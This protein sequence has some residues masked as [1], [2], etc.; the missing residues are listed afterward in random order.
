MLTP[1]AFE[2]VARG[3]PSWPEYCK[4]SKG[5]HDDQRRHES[6]VREDSLPVGGG[7][8]ERIGQDDVLERRDGE[9]GVVLPARVLAKRKNFRQ[10]GQPVEEYIRIEGS[11]LGKNSQSQCHKQILE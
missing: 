4:E 7:L 1:S 9:D 5:S 2:R 8:G 10:Q 3:S 6:V 11:I